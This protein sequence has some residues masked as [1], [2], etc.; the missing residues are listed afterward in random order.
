MLGHSAAAAANISDGVTVV[1]T[2]VDVAGRESV[3]IFFEGTCRAVAIV[4]MVSGSGIGVVGGSVAFA[5][6]PLVGVAFRTTQLQ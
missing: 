2:F 3:S 4:D 5:H 1:R 6:A